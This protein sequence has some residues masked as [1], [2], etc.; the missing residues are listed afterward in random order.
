MYL[1]LSKARLNALV[2]VTTLVGFIVASGPELAWTRLGWTLLGT[3]LAAAS[4][5]ALNQLAEHRRDAKMVR[6]KSRP[7]PAGAIHRATALTLGL[8]LGYAGGAILALKVDL[9]TCALAVGN[10]LVYVLVYT[11]LKPR[12]SFNTLVGALCGA[13]PPM[14]GA[15]AAEGRFGAA[16]FVLGGLLFVWQLPHFMA[17]AWM[18]RDDYARGGFAMLPVVEPSGRVTA[19]VALGCSL[20]TVIVSLLA[21]AEDLA[22]KWYAAIA[23][24]VGVWMCWRAWKFCQDR[25]DASARR[26]FFASITY[27]PVVLTAMALDRVPMRASD[28]ASEI[29]LEHSAPSADKP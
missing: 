8:V 11:P 25:S 27:L 14:I 7:I 1:Q 19:E 18:Y 17:L 3:A 23:L 15:V 10:I 2:L 24:A 29:H 22:G 28:S 16:S 5:A 12:T 26:L 6:T 13:V 20:C 21:V 9:V 4:S